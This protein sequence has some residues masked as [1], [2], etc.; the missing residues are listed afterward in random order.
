MSPLVVNLRVDCSKPAEC[1][2]WWTH[3]QAFRVFNDKIGG[4]CWDCLYDDFAPALAFIRV[5]SLQ[6]LGEQEDVENAARRELMTRR[7]SYRKILNDLSAGA[8]SDMMG[9]HDKIQ[10]EDGSDDSGNPDNSNNQIVYSSSSNAVGECSFSVCLCVCLCFLL[11]HYSLGDFYE[12]ILSHE[13]FYNYL[14][15]FFYIRNP[16]HVYKF[17]I[18]WSMNRIRKLVAI[19]GFHGCYLFRHRRWFLLQA[20]WFWRFT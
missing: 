2:S 7:P 18:S 8:G 9:G 17:V 11:L 4:E 20:A 12:H 5:V 14:Q 10:E 1:I 15:G 13:S 19:F 3:G 16:N 6:S